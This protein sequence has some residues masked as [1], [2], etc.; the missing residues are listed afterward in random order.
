MYSTIDGAKQRAN[1]LDKVM[2]TSGFVFPLRKSQHAVARGGGFRDWHDMA[3]ALKKQA[4]HCDSEAFRRRLL[5]ALPPPCE[6]PVRAW[7]NREPKEEAPSGDVPAGWYRYVFPYQF[8]AAA[9]L[10][11]DPAIRRGSGPGQRLR[12]KLVPGVLLNVNGGHNPYPRLEPDTLALV[13]KGTPET[14]FG[15]DARHPRFAIELRALQDV[16]IIDVR[17]GYVAIVPPDRD[18]ILDRVLRDKIDMVTY[19]LGER[20]NAKDA[21]NA[22]RNA[23][24]AIGIDDALRLAETLLQSG[25]DAYIL[26]SGPIKETLRDLA[27]AGR[28]QAFARFFDLAATIWPKDKELVR[29]MIPAIILNA[30][31]AEHL[32]LIGSSRLIAWTANT[33]GWAQDVDAALAAPVTFERVVRGMAEAIRSVP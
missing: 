1:S 3:S 29:G 12:E 20:G 26:P 23:L 11:H 18:E 30:Y 15:V 8:T 9:M 32:G 25:G 27:A 17:E 22:L 13:F 19:W 16:G 7:L 21:G 10:R 5:E 14:I 4:R 31:L 28:L 2:K 24:A 6:A 33:P